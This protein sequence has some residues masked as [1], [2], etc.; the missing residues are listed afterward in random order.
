MSIEASHVTSQQMRHPFWTCKKRVVYHSQQRSEDH[1]KEN[2]DL[3][4]MPIYCCAPGC[5]NSQ[6]TGKNVSFYR[7]PTDLERRRRWIAAINRK[8]WQPSVY[9]RLC[10]DHFVGG[11]CR[12]KISCKGFT[13]LIHLP[14][15]ALHC[16]A[17]GVFNQIG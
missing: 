7:I 16:M 6:Q 3:I 12:I 5:S 1:S 13:L 11:K 9:Q 4:I 14:R 8:D 10:S 17:A 2:T 15:K